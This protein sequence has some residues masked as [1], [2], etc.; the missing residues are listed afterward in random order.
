[1]PAQPVTLRHATAADHAAL[2]D[3]AALD[4]ARLP[5]WP[6]L[7]AEVDGEL[8]AALSLTDDKVIADPFHPTQELVAMLHA[9][10]A[11]QAAIQSRPRAVARRRR[12]PRLA[13]GL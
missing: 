7:V 6:F 4:S 8:R 12:L 9:H 1:M 13:L 11:A 10:G 2:T 5:H 3:L